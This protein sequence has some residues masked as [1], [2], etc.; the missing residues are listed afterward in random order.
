[1]ASHLT[2]RRTHI[3]WPIPKTKSNP[4]GH[5]R[6]IRYRA[7]VGTAI[8]ENLRRGNKKPLTDMQCR[9]ADILIC[10]ALDTQIDDIH[11]QIHT[12]IEEDD[13]A[14]QPDR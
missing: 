6:R 5:E 1:M 3:T 14:A 12:T 11:L 4:F 2:E 13:E 8:L 7:T 9:I 10:R